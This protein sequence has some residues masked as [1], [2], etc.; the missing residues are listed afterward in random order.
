MAPPNPVKFI[1]HSNGW[2]SG[3]SFSYI[4]NFLG[5]S[6]SPRQN[7]KQLVQLAKVQGSP[8][9][10]GESTTCAY[11]TPQCLS[12]IIWD[13]NPSLILK[14][15]RYPHIETASD[16][17]EQLRWSC[18]IFFFTKSVALMH[19]INWFFY[20]GF[21]EYIELITIIV[22]PLFFRFRARPLLISRIA[23][24]I[25]FTPANE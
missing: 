18:T 10:P 21:I 17:P 23:R 15:G 8:R 7:P 1:N 14:T 12:P 11:S 22:V 6:S 5:A 4:G 25:S 19:M 20:V 16:S 2:R 3:R 24:R 9:I 13:A